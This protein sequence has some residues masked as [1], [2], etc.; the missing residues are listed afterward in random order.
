[1]NQHSEQTTQAAHTASRCP[2]GRVGT[3]LVALA[4]LLGLVFVD[5]AA[6]SGA[7]TRAS[8][9]RP[10]VNSKLP[11]IGGVPVEG[12]ILRADPGK[13]LG[14]ARRP[15]QFSFQWRLCD[16]AGLSCNDIEQATD[17]VYVVQSGDVGKTLRV[18][19]TATNAAGAVRARSRQTGLAQPAPDKAPVVTIRPTIV[20]TAEAGTTLTARPG[21]WRGGGPLRIE[22][23]WRRCDSKGGACNDLKVTDERYTLRTPDVGHSMRVLVTA[24]NSIGSGAGLSLPTPKVKPSA[25]SATAPKNTQ[26]PT[27]AGT[28]QQGETLTAT[29][30]SWSGTAPMSFSF[31][32][33]RCGRGGSHCG[34]VAGAT[35]QAYTVRGADVGRTLRVLVRA[36]NAA[37]ASSVVSAR[38]RVV[39]GLPAS[40][41]PPKI[42]GQPTISGTA[43]ER[44]TLTTSTG[45]WSG[46]PPFT[47]QYRWLRCDQSGGGVNGVTCSTIPGE[48]R[49]TYVLAQAD[50]GHRIR[51]RVIATNKYGAS[52]FNSNATVVVQAAVALSK[53][54]STAPPT[55]SGSPIAGQ[56]LH[57]TTGSWSGGQPITF[58]YQWRRCD[59]NGGSCSS[60]NGATGSSYALKAS[61][62][63]I[64]LR[65]QVTAA[66]KSGSSSATSV[67]TAVIVQSVSS[68][69]AISITDVGLPNRLIIDRVSFGPSRLRFR[70][71]VIARFRVADSNNR[72]VQGALVKVIGIPFGQVP[73]P[74]E[75]ATGPNGY[76]RFALYPTR[77]YHGNG[78]VFFVRARK[79]GER[80]IGGVSTRRLV[81]LPG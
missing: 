67:P 55:I 70:R 1:M 7:V 60:I 3:L 13:W 19:V 35:G 62:V 18:V 53:P 63:G 47:Y 66:N 30:G 15:S 33:Q 48:T 2:S 38:T 21:T 31:Q 69:A 27:I 25:T 68:T 77:R 74:P 26:R 41:A 36:E 17:R 59:R 22:Y 64:T 32:W 39:T 71:R 58:A 61:D 6:G 24:E 42:T 49:K 52:S 37:G 14:H 51:S 75:Q 16:A 79:P 34:R 10:P 12:R 4:I 78:I 28:A 80:L 56:T 65:V 50:V 11:T 54:Q 9:Q 57:A 73:T 45:S 29:T 44:G 81:Y 20:G 5:L 23:H 43:V 40:P 46:T 76:A 8:S 72:A